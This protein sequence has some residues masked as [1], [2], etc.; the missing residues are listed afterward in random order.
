MG[1]LKNVERFEDGSSLWYEEDGSV[2]L[3]DKDGWVGRFTG[4]IDY[5]RKTHKNQEKEGN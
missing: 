3:K 5:Y 2:W 1:K 4:D